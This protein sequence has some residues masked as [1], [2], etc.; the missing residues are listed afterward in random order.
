MLETIKTAV[1]RLL[2]S[3]TERFLLSYTV[4]PL[5]FNRKLHVRDKQM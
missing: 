4:Y 2:L 3:G 5:T 1:N